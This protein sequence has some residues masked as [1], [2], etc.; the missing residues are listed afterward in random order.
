YRLPTIREAASIMG[1]PITYQFKGSEHTKWKLIGNA[2]CPPVSRVI[3]LNVLKFLNIKPSSELILEKEVN[4]NEII[5]LNTFSQ[6]K[7]DNPPQKQKG[8]KCRWHTFKDGNLTVSLSNFII[9]NNTQSKENW[10]TSIQYGTGKG[11]P[12]QIIPE[13]KYLDLK[14]FI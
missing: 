11:F 9:G 3:A 14:D 13:N 12:S 1:F 7:F 5:N 2:V 10:I 8:A 6:K 4:L